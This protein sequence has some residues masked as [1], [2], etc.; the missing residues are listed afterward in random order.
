[1]S[2]II[3]IKNLK[4]LKINKCPICKKGVTINFDPFCSK[5]CSDIDLYN[6]ISEEY[7][8]PENNKSQ[9]E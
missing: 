3:K 4:K 5:K 1:M 7:Y 2:K 8:F 9:S 6:W